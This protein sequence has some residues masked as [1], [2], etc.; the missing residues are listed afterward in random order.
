LKQGRKRDTRMKRLTKKQCREM[1]WSYS[2][3]NSFH[4]CPYSFHKGY[5]ERADGDTNAF[6]QYG[7]FMHELIEKILKEELT[8]DKAVREYERSFD[9][10]VTKK[11]PHLK[12]CN[13]REKY[14]FEGWKYLRWFEFPYKVVDIE[15]KIAIEIGGYK[16]TGFIDVVC[17]HEDRFIV[18]DHKSKGGIKPKEREEYFRQNYIYSLAIEQ[19]Y[20]EEPI[21]LILNLFRQNEMLKEKFSKESQLEASDWFVNTIKKIEKEKNFER[22]K[23]PE[24]DFFCR[25]ICSHGEECRDAKKC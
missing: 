9:S 21:G 7:T 8:V 19:Q 5:V 23:V 12:N 17:K 13:F 16:T 15:Q 2:R 22:A 18:L 20:G 14:W 11:F 3:V 1:T 24:K 25:Y 4:T 6:A 10:R